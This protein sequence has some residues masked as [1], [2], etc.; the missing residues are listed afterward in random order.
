MYLDAADKDYDTAALDKGVFVHDPTLTG[1]TGVVG[2]DM[3]GAAIQAGEGL[4]MPPLARSP[5][6][7][8]ATS[9]DGNDE[10]VTATVWYKTG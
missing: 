3:T 9:Q 5:L 1:L 4:L 2:V 10:V 6:T 7:L 8:T